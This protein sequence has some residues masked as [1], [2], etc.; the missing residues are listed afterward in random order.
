MTCL[1]YGFVDYSGKETKSFDVLTGDQ[2]LEI[3]KPKIDQSQHVISVSHK[4]YT[5]VCV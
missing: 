4:I 3:Y 1:L 2:K 5:V